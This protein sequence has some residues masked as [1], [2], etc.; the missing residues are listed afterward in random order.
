MDEE[1]FGEL[2]ESVEEAA[3][4]S[5][6]E[7]EPSR[8][9][10]FPTP[11]PKAVREKLGLSQEKF[12]YLTGAS[13]STVRNWEQGRREPNGLVTTLLA[14]LDKKPEVICQTFPGIEGFLGWEK[15]PYEA[16]VTDWIEFGEPFPDRAV[17]HAG[18]VK[19]HKV[20]L[21]ISQEDNDLNLDPS[22]LRQLA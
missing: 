16:K 22:E 17:W 21:F 1:L 13:L 15:D 14:I 10:A 20:E 19:Q 8:Q 5:H 4:I 12:A 6:G 18:V 9:I 7:K 2:L 11:E 3:R